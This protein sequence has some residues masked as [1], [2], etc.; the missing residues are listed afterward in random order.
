MDEVIITRSG[1]SQFDNETHNLF[2][3]VSKCHKTNLEI[4]ANLNNL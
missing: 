2:P 1:Y 4:D 3:T